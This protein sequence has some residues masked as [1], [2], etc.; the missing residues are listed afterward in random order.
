MTVR[1]FIKS[2]T[3]RPGEPYIEF[4]VCGQNHRVIGSCMRWNSKEDDFAQHM[5]AW[6]GYEIASW[7][8]GPDPQ[9]CDAVIFWITVMK[10]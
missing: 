2:N 1:D 3:N 8:I 6:G 5:E 10:R 4:V 9:D 7:Y